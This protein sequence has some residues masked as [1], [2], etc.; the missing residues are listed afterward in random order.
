MG[1]GFR[2]EE[3]MCGFGPGPKCQIHTDRHWVGESRLCRAWPTLPPRGR[4]DLGHLT[5][6]ALFCAEAGAQAALDGWHRAVL[7]GHHV[8]EVCPQRR[9]S[10][11]PQP[12][13][14]MAHTRCCA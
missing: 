14:R 4:E 10:G 3:R 6:E 5:C 1:V 13:H 7:A 8:E 11:A 9:N 2:N 12:P